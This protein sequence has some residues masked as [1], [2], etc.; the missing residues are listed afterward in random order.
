[1]IGGLTYSDFFQQNGNLAANSSVGVLMKSP[2]KSDAQIEKD[3]DLMMK[4]KYTPHSWG[5]TKP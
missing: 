4:L 5:Y 3:S 2:N 1:M